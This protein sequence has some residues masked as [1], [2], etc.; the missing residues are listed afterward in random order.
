MKKILSSLILLGVIALVLIGVS[1]AFFSDTETSKDNLLQAGKLDLKIDNESFY[2]G[3]PSPETSWLPDDLPGHLFFNFQDLKPG[4]W[5]EDTISLRV[6]DNDAW[7]CMNISLKED[8]DETC[9]EPELGDDPSCDDPDDDIADGELANL[10]EFVFWADDG[11]NVLEVDENRDEG[12]F[13]LG[14]AEEV[15][16]G[17]II[18]L[19]DALSGVLGL[20]GP[21]KG[22]ETYYIGKAWCFGKLTP[23]P[24]PDDEGIDPTVEDGIDCDGSGLNNATQTDKVLVD[25]EFSAYQRRHNDNFTCTGERPSITP[26]THTPTPTPLACSKADVMLVLDRSGSIASGELALLK[27]AAKDF[28]DSL[29]LAA[30]GNH[31]GKS[32]FST[33][34]SLNHHLTSDPVSL[35]AAIDA[36]VAGGFTNLSGGI[37]LAKNELDNP[38]DGHDRADGASPDKMVIITD[39]HPNRPLPSSTAD[40]VAATSADNARAAGSEIFVVGIGVD[41][42]SETFLKTEIADDASHYFSVTDY[43]GLQTI[44]D[45]LDICE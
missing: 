13:K 5:G 22:G 37:D 27:I 8:D 24:V 11:D 35:K 38:G 1:S 16:D 26:S 14:T 34:A 17:K 21:F 28:V 2:N 32:S 19:A 15:F 41:A 45:K 25:F 12:V 39:G 9:N 4:D 6:D 43:G 33:T 44:L 29:G 36:M 18:S 42:T 10:L 20:G 7:A 30:D 40:D 31:A 3:K 23:N